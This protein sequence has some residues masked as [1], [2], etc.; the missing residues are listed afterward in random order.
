MIFASCLL[1]STGRYERVLLGCFCLQWKYR[2]FFVSDQLDA[3]LR[4]VIRIIIFSMFRA[5]LCSSSGGKIALIQH[6][7]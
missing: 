6:L 1:H 3:Q 4:Y 5:T 2:S 7:V